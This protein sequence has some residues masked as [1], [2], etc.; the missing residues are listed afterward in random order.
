MQLSYILINGT[1]ILVRCASTPLSSPAMKS[2]L[3]GVFPGHMLLLHLPSNNSP[4]VLLPHSLSP[5]T[6]L[7]LL[8]LSCLENL[9]PHFCPVIGYVSSLL[10]NQI[11]KGNS[12]TVTYFNKITAPNPSN[13]F[14]QFRSLLTEY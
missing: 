4:S 13:S 14:K 2:L 6:P 12:S 10:A 8:F 3:L 5:P 7:T 1:P 11:I 9:P